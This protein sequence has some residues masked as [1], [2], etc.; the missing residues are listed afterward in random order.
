[1]IL[2]LTYLL[3]KEFLETIAVCMELIKILLVEDDFED[4]EYLKETLSEVQ[5]PFKV[6]N[7]ETLEDAMICLDEKE[8]DIVLLDLNLPD[9]RGV[10][11]FTTINNHRQKKPIIVMSGNLNETLALKTVHMGAQDY[12]MKGKVDGELLTKSIRYAMGRYKV[13]E[14]LRDTNQKLESA[15]EELQK[16]Q[17]Q[18]IRQERLRALGEMTSGIVHDFN[19]FLASIVGFSDLLLMRS[20]YLEDAERTKHYLEMINT[21]GKDSAE[22]IKRLSSFYR[23]KDSGGTLV[24]VDLPSVVG[25]TIPLT[26]PKW[27]DQARDKGVEIE[28]KKELTEIPFVSGNE[29]ELREVLTNLIFNATDAIRH[30][31]TITIRTRLDQEEDGYALLEVSDTG[32]GMPEEV[33]EKCLEP[34]FSTKGDDGTGLGLSMVFGV[35][36]R[37]QGDIRIESELHKGTNFVI[38]LPLHKETYACDEK[39]VKELTSQLRVLVVDSN[40][41]VCSFLE[42]YFSGEGHTVT[43]AYDGIQGL[44]KFDKTMHDLVITSQGIPKINGNKLAETIKKIAPQ[45]PVVMLTGFGEVSSLNEKLPT[46]VDFVL[47]KPL[48]I[49][50]LH[51]V[52]VEIELGMEKGKKLELKC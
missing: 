33:Q 17:K 41:G 2:R 39:E 6:I 14:E 3:S 25:K 42:E 32:S 44:E 13:E 31:G 27:R 37:H 47:G 19:N 10:D 45:I 12:L 1:M 21:A 22:V 24:A 15:V 26:E 18:A 52:L 23:S 51:E 28:I 46:G 35:I 29:S 38:K 16:T 50:D 49:N 4:V 40:L 48:F 36:K 9:S 11:T 8:T 7:V 30:R 20:E 43:L 5:F 34:F